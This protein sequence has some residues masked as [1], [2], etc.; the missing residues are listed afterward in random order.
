[1]EML[2]I[3]TDYEEAKTRG[4]FRRIASYTAEELLFMA[5]RHRFFNGPYLAGKGFD[6]ERAKEE[7]GF[8]RNQLI[9]LKYPPNDLN[10]IGITSEE[11]DAFNTTAVP[12]D[13]FENLRKALF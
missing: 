5:E 10:S 13:G 11:I 4:K 8:N 6:A 12:V 2:N 9:A 3:K 7:L 1:M